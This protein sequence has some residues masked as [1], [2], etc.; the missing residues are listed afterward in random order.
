MMTVVQ[1]ATLAG[2]AR[3]QRCATACAAVALGAGVLLPIA[4]C[5]SGVA[6]SSAM[7]PAIKP[8]ESV[9]IDF[10]AYAFSGPSR[11]DVVALEPPGFTNQVLLKRVIG[12]PGETV[13]LT[14]SWDSRFHG[15]V[16]KSEIPGKVKNK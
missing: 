16:A 14:N 9:T 13:S 15:A 12:L 10:A 2:A 1:R 5:G 4:G 6:P 8:G 3:L 7:S 11:W